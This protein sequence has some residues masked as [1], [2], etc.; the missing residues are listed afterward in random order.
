MRFV[1][2]AFVV[3]ARADAATSVQ[4]GFSEGI[5]PLRI[6]AGEPG[7]SASGCTVCHA[8]EGREWARSRHRYAYSNEIFLLGYTQEPSA[9]CIGCHAPLVEQAR[10]LEDAQEG[11][12][13]TVAAVPPGALVHEGITC[14]VCHVRDG[15]VLTARPVS[16]AM[17][18]V[19][20]LPELRDS[21]F[22]ANC[23]QFRFTRR[24]K[25]GRSELGSPMQ[26]T[27]DEWQAYL[28][29]GGSKTCQ[30]CHM[31]GGSHAFLGA[32][33]EETLQG[34]LRME[35]DECQSRVRVWTVDVGHQLPTGDVF[36]RLTLDV[37]LRSGE[38]RRLAVF[39]RRFAST[40]ELGRHLV[41]DTS[42]HPGRT[43]EV[44]I[45]TD[46]ASVHLRY[47]FLAEDSEDARVL[48][49]GDM[50]TSV[51]E[52]PVPRCERPAWADETRPHDPPG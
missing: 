30:D 41:E 17:H 5:H 27:Y 8:K 10:E 35:V 7:L 11:L 40:E 25:H 12:R 15:A 44:E 28:E 38:V 4:L 42:L 22:C 45:P 21:R 14:A 9:R 46:A 49:Q 29:G 32:H 33:D 20:P 36:R 31:P 52:L 2:V 50:I 1:L 18:A 24:G 39:G 43:E 51:I 23:H 19:T 37:R 47:H 34:A 48:P 26:T 16:G 13:G 6:A 3:L